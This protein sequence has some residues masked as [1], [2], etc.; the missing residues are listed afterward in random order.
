MSCLQDGG[1]HKKAQALPL[2]R[3]ARNLAGDFG[4][5][6]KM[7]AKRGERRRE[8]G[9]G[10][11]VPC[12]ERRLLAGETGDSGAF[13]GAVVQLDY[14]EEIGPLLGMYGSVEVQRTIKR[15][16]LTAFFWN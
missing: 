4:A 3:M 2:P 13:G 9:S 12:G 15:A 11:E 6:Q 10:R 16:E 1:R 14:D 8:R 5:L 7:G